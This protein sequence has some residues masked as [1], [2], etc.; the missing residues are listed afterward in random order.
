MASNGCTA[1]GTAAACQ[2]VTTCANGTG[3]C[4]CPTAP[5][6]CTA[7]GTFCNT[8]GDVVTCTRDAQGCFS[9]S[10]PQACPTDESCKGNLPNAACSCDNDP[11]CHGTNS[12]CVNASTVATCG[13]DA[14]QPA[15]NVVVTTHR[16]GGS[17]TC[18]GGACICPAVGTT[19]GTGCSTLNATPARAPTS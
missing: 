12:F 19:A 2:G 16:C 11:S 6:R 8:N 10:T 15:C 18:V 9:A 4:T 5:A 3:V 14:N 7:A 13:S 1:W 17:S